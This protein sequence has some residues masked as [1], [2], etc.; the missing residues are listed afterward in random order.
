MHG[1]CILPLSVCDV[2]SI[3]NG[4]LIE[5]HIPISIIYG[6]TIGW[7]LRKEAIKQMLPIL[8]PLCV[9]T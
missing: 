3:Y 5:S 7:M 4:I 9:F 1:I 8:L 6:N 2:C